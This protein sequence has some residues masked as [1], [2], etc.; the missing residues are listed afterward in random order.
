M[1]IERKGR[2]STGRPRKLPKEAKGVLLDEVQQLRAENI[3]L[4]NLNALV[5]ERIRQE[6]NQKNLK[7]E[8]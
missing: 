4:K 8:A 3:Y 6:K 5:A 1:Y 2:K 7:A